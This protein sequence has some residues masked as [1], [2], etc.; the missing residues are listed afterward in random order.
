M[1][2]TLLS[3]AILSSMSLEAGALEEAFIKSE[4]SGQVRL[5]AVQSK[6]STGDKE[7]TVALGGRLGIK[8]NPVAGISAAATF[9]TTNAIL[10]HSDNGMF[11]NSKNGGYSIVGEAYIQAEMGKT[12][13]KVGRQVVDTPYADSDDIGMIP[14]TFEGVTLINQDIPD[15][16][17]ILAV[18]S[19]WS[20]VDTEI[21]EKFN[22]MQASGDAVYVGGLIYEGIENTT[23]QAWQYKLDD[24]D[25]NYVEAGYETESYSVAT[26]YIDQG[27]NNTAFGFS[28]AVNVGNLAVNAAYNKAHGTVNNGFGGGPF[29]TSSEEHTVAE[30][31]DQEA[32][33]V[34]AEY[35]INDV[36]LA[37]THV[38]FEKGE[39]ET[40]YVV[41]YSANEKLSFDVIHADMHGD[42]KLIR[43]FANYD[44]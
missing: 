40:D 12:S 24:T 17:V 37:V 33:L 1:K 36:T 5:G 30:V 38:N 35:R 25:F 32:V 13:L 19:R 22:E 29:F 39:N 6:N 15:T 26:Q 4:V 20:G 14:N 11:L 16:T 10:G 27:H 34:G 3:L 42:G 44:F 43:V 18:L 8:T 28:G 9:Y 31:V 23:L 7:S 2:T 21:P 41:S